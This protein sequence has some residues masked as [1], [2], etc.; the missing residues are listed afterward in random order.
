[1]SSILLKINFKDK[2]N[3]TQRILQKI[4]KEILQLIL[5]VNI[6]NK[7]ENIFINYNIEKK[8]I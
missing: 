4:C 1:M 2:K 8:Q 5:S 3:L 6:F 7:K